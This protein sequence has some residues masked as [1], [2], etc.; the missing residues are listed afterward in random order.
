MTKETILPGTRANTRP[1]RTVPFRLMT[2]MIKPHS[3]VPTMVP[4]TLLIL[5]VDVHVTLALPDRPVSSLLWTTLSIGMRMNTS[6]TRPSP[7][8]MT[9]SA[10]MEAPVKP[11]ELAIA[12]LLSLQPPCLRETRVR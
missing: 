5:V 4:V 11:M 6:I 3:F 8:V 2:M 9:R 12:V 10:I 7:V 1:P